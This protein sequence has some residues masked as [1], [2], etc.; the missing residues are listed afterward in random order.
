MGRIFELIIAEPTIHFSVTLVL[1]L[2]SILLLVVMFILIN[3][4]NKLRRS[5]KIFMQ[6]E[7]GKSI[8]NKVQSYMQET[9]KHRIVI[10]DLDKRLRELT[11]KNDENI[12]KV[13]MTRFSAFSGVG[14][15]LSFALALMDNKGKGVVLSSICGRDDNRFYAKPIED[16]NSTYRLS[17]EEEMAIKKALGK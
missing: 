8:E 13:G 7:D 11:L 10:E 2:L 5:F 15:D 12:Q 6:G 4:N 16:G 1:F 9:E 3:Y 14:G 17:L